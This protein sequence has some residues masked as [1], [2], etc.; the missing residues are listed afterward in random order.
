MDNIFDQIYFFVIAF[1]VI[2]GA[3]KLLFWFSMFRNVF[4]AVQ[5]QQQQLN[6]FLALFGIQPPPP[7]NPEV[8]EAQQRHRYAT[9]GL[10]LGAGMI[11]VGVLMI[12]TG[13][14]GGE[15][16]TFTFLELEV[17]KATPGIVFALL[18][19]YVVKLTASRK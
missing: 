16:A 7:P 2:G 10:V 11:I 17:N 1:V 5:Q 12:I 9:A 13:V 18:G 14:G 19:T 6:P 4:G 3:L 15:S 8:I